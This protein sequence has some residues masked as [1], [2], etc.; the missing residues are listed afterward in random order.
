VTLIEL[1]V[2][3]A[4][5]SILV[6]ILVPAVQ[7]AR[8]AARKVSC[9]QNLRQ[10]GL[11]L[12]NYIAAYDS[13]PLSQTRGEGHGN[14]HSVFTGL[15]PFLERAPM[16]NMYNTGLENWHI[17]NST[18]V[19]TP[20]ETYLC[21]DNPDKENVAAGE[22]RFP[23]SRS[24]FAKTHYGGNWGGGRGPWG[25]DFVK[26]RGTYLG[27]MMTVITPDGQVKGPDGKPKA[28]AVSLADILDCTSSTLAFVEKQD[29]FGWPVGGWGGSEFDVHTGPAYQGDD[30]LAG[31]V[32]SGSPHREGPN[33]VMCDASVRHLSPTLDRTLWYALITRAGRETVKFK[34]DE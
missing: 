13:C 32:Y 29:S 14:G 3:V 1:L 27:V 30:P 12:G 10:I 9:E 26:Q 20:V 23:E 31:K 24:S 2:V 25:E 34:S 6:A 15:L 4:V 28:R 16:Y 22:V 18:V 17:A 21:L 5:I 8:A 11:A 7:T 33:A 19:G